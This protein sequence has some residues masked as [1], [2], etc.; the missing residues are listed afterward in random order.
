MVSDMATVYLILSESIIPCDFVS[1]FAQLSC[2]LGSQGLQQ[3][4]CLPKS[5]DVV[6]QNYL[7]GY[8][9]HRAAVA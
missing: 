5:L 2:L 6:S 9:S 8:G 3:M 1:S 4:E 7:G